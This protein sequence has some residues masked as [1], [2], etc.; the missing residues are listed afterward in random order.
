M[1]EALEGFRPERRTPVETVELIDALARVPA[2]PLRAAHA[3]PGF[4]PAI[5]RQALASYLCA[6]TVPAPA[7]ARS[8]PAPGSISLPGGRPGPGRSSRP[9]CA[10]A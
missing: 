9:A 3:L 10:P 1:A 8:P 6:G 2:E 7:N 4:A 5:D